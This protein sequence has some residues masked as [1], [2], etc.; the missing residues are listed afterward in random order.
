MVSINGPFALYWRMVM[1]VDAGAVAQPMA[2]RSRLKDRDRP[3]SSMAVVMNTPAVRD[4]NRVSMTMFF[5]L[6]FRDESLKYLPTPKAMKARATS[7][8]NSIPLVISA[9]IRSSAYGPMAT[10]ARI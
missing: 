6:A 3:N 8:T 10:P 2:P 7:V 5:P 4:S 1:M 9:G